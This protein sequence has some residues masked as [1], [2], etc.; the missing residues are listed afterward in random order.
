[1]YGP[2]N[3]QAP[4]ADFTPMNHPSMAVVRH[5]IFVIASHGETH[6]RFMIWGPIIGQVKSNKWTSKDSPQE[7]NGRYMSGIAIWEKI[8]VYS[9]WLINI[10]NS[11]MTAMTLWSIYRAG[12]VVLLLGI[13]FLLYRRALYAN[14][15][16][17]S[18]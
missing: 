4:S 10:A 2:D 1:M 13:Y 9:N 16:Y 8:Y 15:I 7:H 12:R 14:L 17:L 6:C 3:T 5:N 18:N 11:S